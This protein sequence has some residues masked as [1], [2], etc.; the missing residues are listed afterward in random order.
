MLEYEAGKRLSQHWHERP[1]FSL[2]TGF[3]TGCVRMPKSTLHLIKKRNKRYILHL[4]VFHSN[5]VG[6]VFSSI[7]EIGT[8]RLQ[9]QTCAEASFSSVYMFV[10]RYLPQTQT[11][12]VS[13]C[14]MAR[15]ADVQRLEMPGN[16]S[17]CDSQVLSDSETNKTCIYPVKSQLPY[18]SP[19]FPLMA[20][21]SYQM[22]Q[23]SCEN[24]LQTC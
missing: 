15:L 6:W 22:R 14:L 4:T 17:V 8:A 23:C 2:K 11:T 3:L 16:H 19:H 1:I 20:I 13:A 18:Y 10:F 5:Q 7:H 9:Y 12:V 24:A 21:M